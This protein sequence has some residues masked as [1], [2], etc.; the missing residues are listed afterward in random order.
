VVA[1]RGK[2]L[3][4]I[5]LHEL[6]SVSV[7]D[8]EGKSECK[9]LSFRDG[10]NLLHVRLL[11]PPGKLI[12]LFVN[13]ILSKMVTPQQPVPQVV[14]NQAGMSSNVPFSALEQAASV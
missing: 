5:K 1:S 12:R 3:R 6:H 2:V 10:L 11:A 7:W 14:T 4:P 9:Q 8:Y 13:H